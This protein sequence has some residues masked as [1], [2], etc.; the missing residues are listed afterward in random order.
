MKKKTADRHIYSHFNLQI[1][2]PFKGEQW[3]YNKVPKLKT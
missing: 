1:D 2:E 3:K